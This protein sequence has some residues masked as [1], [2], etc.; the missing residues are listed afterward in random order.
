M[1]HIWAEG[2]STRWIRWKETAWKTLVE[3]GDNIK[4]I[5]EITYDGFAWTGP[6]WLRVETC[7]VPL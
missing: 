1:W 6:M 2:R 7:E 5:F 3:M 4:D